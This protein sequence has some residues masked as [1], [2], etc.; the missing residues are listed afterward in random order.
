MG[1]FKVSPS[2]QADL[3][4]LLAPKALIVADTVVEF[5]REKLGNDNAPSQPGDYP[6]KVSGALYDSISKQEVAPLHYEAGMINGPPEGFY[7]EYPAPPNSPYRK[8]TPNG[9]RPW[10]SKA[11]H[12]EQ[13]HARIHQALARGG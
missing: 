3:Q 13:L 2:L 12:D 11:L 4:R 1:T 10:I 5:L 8:L 7:L 6:A 9:A